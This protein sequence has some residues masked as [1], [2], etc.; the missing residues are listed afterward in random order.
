MSYVRNAAFKPIFRH[1]TGG[2][3]LAASWAG[4]ETV[5]FVEI[6]P[7]CQRVLTA[8]FPGVPIFAD[9]RTVTKK[10]LIEAGVIN[11]EAGR[12]IDVISGGFP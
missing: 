6:N 7:F 3:D 4:M 11:S 5:A 9:I 10:S 12:G 1:L 2:L 8:R